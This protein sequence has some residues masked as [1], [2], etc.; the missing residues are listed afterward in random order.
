MYDDLKASMKNGYKLIQAI[1][2]L[3]VQDQTAI[4]RLI[5]ICKES[6]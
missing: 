2:K 1:S 6:K 3:P 5:T 4:E